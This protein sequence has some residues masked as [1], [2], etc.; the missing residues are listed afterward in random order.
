MSI[1]TPW[2]LQ[3]ARANKG[4]AVLDA[5]LVGFISFSF[6]YMFSVS[7]SNLSLLCVSFC[8]FVFFSYDLLLSQPTFLRI[9]RNRRKHNFNQS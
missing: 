2:A 5:I 3:S 7:S 4:L 6:V 8:F 1:T 9:A